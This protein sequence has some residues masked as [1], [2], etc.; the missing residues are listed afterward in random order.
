[1]CSMATERVRLIVEGTDEVLHE[2]PRSW[3]SDG[4]EPPPPEPTEYDRLP[5]YGEVVDFAGFRVLWVSYTLDDLMMGA[6]R[7]T[8]NA[9]ARAFYNMIT[10]GIRMRPVV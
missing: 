5:P 6:L 7:W 3:S 2:G 1:M 4:L 10:D 9:D 8:L